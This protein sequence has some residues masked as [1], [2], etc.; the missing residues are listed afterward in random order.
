LQLNVKPSCLPADTSQVTSEVYEEIKTAFEKNNIN[1]AK[2]NQY[3][4]I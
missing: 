1:L 2:L 3:E 4:N